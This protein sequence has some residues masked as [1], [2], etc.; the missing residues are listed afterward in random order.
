MLSFRIENCI[1][2]ISKNGLRIVVDDQNCVQGIA[3]FKSDLFT[4]FI[5]NE[6]VITFR[7]PLCIFTECLSAF[8][9]GV[10][11]VLKMTYDGYGE[12][13][14][15]MLEKDGVVARCLIKTQSPDIVLDFDF[16]PANVTAKVIMKPWMLKETFHEFDQS[17]PF[18]GFRVDQFSLSVITEGDLGKIKTKF[19]HNSEQIERLECRQDVEFTYRLNLVKRMTASLDIC[20]KLSGFFVSLLYL[21][22]IRLHA[23]AQQTDPL[24]AFM[25]A[26]LKSCFP[27]QCVPDISAS[28]EEN[29]SMD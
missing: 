6:D 25:I 5:L 12:P 16:N 9:A 15:V 2:D 11:T 14:K 27:L 20:N 1:V 29:I 13:L 21:G 3:Y 22:S 19:P 24:V 8:G 7:I 18:V 17:S 4:D 10:S 28:E 23:I 26:W